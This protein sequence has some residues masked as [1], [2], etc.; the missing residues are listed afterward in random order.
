VSAFGTASVAEI[1]RRGRHLHGETTAQ[2]EVT[3]GICGRSW[4]EACDGAPSALC[5]WCHG[6]GHSTAPIR[7]RRTDPERLV[8]TCS[9][10]ATLALHEPACPIP[11]S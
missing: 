4:C 1:N 2:D 3:C 5:H 11:G 6:R 9:R 10:S 7:K 8:C